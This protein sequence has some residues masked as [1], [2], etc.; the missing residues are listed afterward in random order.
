MARIFF[1]TNAPTP[2]QLDFFDELARHHD[3]QVVHLFRELRNLAWHLPSRPW[4]HEL[5]RGGESVELWRRLRGFRPEVV[6]IGGYSLPLSE[7]CKWMAR[8]AGAKVFYW[9]EK[10][11][12][13][14]PWKALLREAVLRTR[15]PTVDGVL[16]IGG[17]AVEAYRPFAR[18]VELLPYSIAPERYQPR[19]GERAPGPVRFLFA[20]QYIERKGV[21]E[22]L[23]AFRG[24]A[25]TEAS[26]TLAGTGPLA[27]AVAAAARAQPQLV[28]AGFVPPDELPAL[29]A[30]SDVFVLPSRFDG[31]AVVVGEAMASGLAIIGTRETGAAAELVV[32]GVSGH[33]CATDARSIA[34][35]MRRYVGR[36]E[37]AAAHGRAARATFLASRASAPVAR[38]AL[39]SFTLRPR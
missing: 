10:P 1:L 25:A 3:V 32:E 23:D 18:R 36:P 5:G 14:P 35:A 8:S 11:N 37:V 19:V 31:W 12:Q 24:F 34:T 21:P 39:E 33:F 16:G 29:F 17:Q 30:R 27:G 28:D 22:L 15:L 9:L 2:Y 6:L 4:L 7:R 13:V 20:G 26:L 38:Q